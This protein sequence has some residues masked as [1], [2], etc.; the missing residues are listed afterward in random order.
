[1]FGTLVKVDGKNLVLSVRQRGGEAQEVT[2]P[3]DE[4]T[5]FLV[6]AEAGK[7]ANLKPEMRVNV[8]QVPA[9]EDKPARTVVMATSRGLNGTVVKVEGKNVVITAREMGGEAR[10]VT[11]A[12]DEKTKVFLLGGMARGTFSEP[13]V[14]KLEDIKAD[15]R[16]MVL[17]ETGTAA[18]IL[19]SPA[20]ARGG[21]RG[22]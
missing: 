4:K 18:K 22:G 5:Q 2:V 12:T 16:V 7:L 1:V 3:T 6:D 8:I 19:A 9:T 15:M 21:R 20:P 10:E 17:P 13:K 14:G 11:V